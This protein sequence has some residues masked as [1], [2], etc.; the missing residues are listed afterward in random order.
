MSEVEPRAAGRE[1]MTSLAEQM[2]DTAPMCVI[3]DEGRILAYGRALLALLGCTHEEIEER[4]TRIITERLR[5]EDLVTLRKALA[6]ARGN[7]L[8]QVEL[9]ECAPGERHFIARSRIILRAEDGKGRR[10]LFTLQDV[11]TERRQQETLRR[12]EALFHAFLEHTPAVMFAKDGEGRYLLSNRMIDE[13]AGHGR[14]WLHGKKDDDYLPKELVKVLLAIDEE[15]RAAGHALHFEDKV[16]H[17]TEGLKTY[18]TV[19]FPIEGVGVPQG[20]IGGVSLDIT[21]MK[22]AEREREAAREALIAAQ[23]ATIRELATP[24][25]PIAEGVI[26][27]PLIGQIDGTRADNIIHTLLNGVG[28]HRARVAILDI[29]GVKTVDAQ[30]ADAL[31]RA[32]R[33]VGLLGA[34]VVLTGIQPQIARTLIELSV[35]LQGIVTQSTLR[36]GIAYALR[37]APSS[38]G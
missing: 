21:A 18:F 6:T 8:I 11:T 38:S 17:P 13:F 16:P 12:T 27:M 35:D 22:E 34:R 28:E 3:D 20:T 33:G 9:R 25:L 29:T 19:K 36:A 31:L 10:V 24:L 4:G 26:V 1:E 7:E 23:E 2:L 5:T 32:A 15:V 37:E 14:G 30:V